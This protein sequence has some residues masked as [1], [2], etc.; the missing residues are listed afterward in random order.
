MRGQP[1]GAIELYRLS[2]AGSGGGAVSARPFDS[3]DTNPYGG[4]IQTLPSSKGTEGNRLWFDKIWLT[5]SIA[6][7]PNSIEWVARDNMKPIIIGSA[8][9]DGIAIKITT[10]IASATVD[11]NVEFTVTP[12]L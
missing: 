1:L 10:G 8:T 5:N 7:Q 11:I 3:A 9:T 4:T 2:T 12:Y 6:A